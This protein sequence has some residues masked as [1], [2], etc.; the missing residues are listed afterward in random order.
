MKHYARNSTCSAS[1]R[2]Y[3]PNGYRQRLAQSHQAK[4]QQTAR[5]L[6]REIPAPRTVRPSVAGSMERLYSVASFRAIDFIIFDDYSHWTGVDMMDQPIE[7]YTIKFGELGFT[8]S[9]KHQKSLQFFTSY[10]AKARKRAF[11]DHPNDRHWR[12]LRAVFVAAEV[13]RKL[14]K[15]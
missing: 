4:E 9:S 14:E 1:S 2:S 5:A 12:P 15:L 3:A 8:I 7:Y 13:A 10:L 6:R 11:S